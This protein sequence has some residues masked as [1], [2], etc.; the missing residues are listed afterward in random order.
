MG[1]VLLISKNELLNSLYEVNLKAY[2]ATSCTIKDNSSSAIGLMDQNMVFDAIIYLNDNSGSIKELVQ[3]LKMQQLQTPL[4]ILGEQESLNELNNENSLVIKNVYDLKMLL[5][6]MAKI[7][8][9]SA[10]QMATMKVAQY[11]PIPLNIL[12]SMDTSHCDI[13]FRHKKEADFEYEYLKLIEK[14]S[15][16]NEKV[17]KFNTENK[18]INKQLYIE[19]N[20]RLRF[21]NRASLLIIK[22]LQSGNLSTQDR[23]T[24]TAQA[25]GMLVEEIFDNPQ[26]SK[27]IAEVSQG[28]VDT[29]NKVVKETSKA[30]DLLKMLTEHKDQ[31]VYMHTVLATYIATG[32]LKNISWGSF[33]Q[34]EKVSFALF[35]HDIFLVPVYQKYPGFHNEEDLLYN[36]YFE[37]RDKEIVL[38]HAR[39]AHDLIK[40]FPNAPIGAD[41]MILQH[42]GMANGKGFAVTFK[43]DISPLAKVMIIA[44]DI[45]TE[46]LMK[47]KVE[48]EV[49]QDFFNKKQITER[50]LEEYDRPSYKKIIE[51]FEHVKLQ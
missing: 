10:E 45:A 48:K 29:I 17:Q 35:F 20:E 24:V 4:L 36:E 37:E 13:Y 15:A 42:H 30:K 7:L 25:M 39:F 41:M 3:Y 16:L 46:I 49:L 32:L 9:V 22:K 51:A 18:E 40:T 2:V 27:E 43:D 11:F 28:C 31:Y 5:R 44:E 26:I 14:D 50:L 8:E 21:I 19:S 33:E 1:H 6:S 38:E 12:N 34:I 23:V 47:V